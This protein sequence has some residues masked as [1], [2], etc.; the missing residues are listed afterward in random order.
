MDIIEELKTKDSLTRTDIA[1]LLTSLGTPGKNREA[2]V[3]A[4]EALEKQNNQGHNIVLTIESYSE[5]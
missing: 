3:A 5:Y 2:K 1:S 4:V